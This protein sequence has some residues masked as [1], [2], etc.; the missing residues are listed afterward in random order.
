M[1]LKRDPNGGGTEADGTRSTM[2]CS[3]CYESGSFTLPGIT[4][5]EMQRRVQQKLRESGLPVLL[6]VFLSR[7]V[8][9]LERWRKA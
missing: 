9:K 8:P 3:H 5:G 6:A 4:V 2:Y 1:P 7:N